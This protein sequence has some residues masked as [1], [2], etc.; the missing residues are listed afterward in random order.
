MKKSIITLTLITVIGTG[1]LALNAYA[2]NCGGPGGGYGARGWTGGYNTT[3]TDA[4]YK[5]FLDETVQIRKSIITDRAELNALMAGQNPDP[6]KAREL[7]AK[8][9]DNE[10]A[11]NGIARSANI[12]GPYGRGYGKTGLCGGPG[13]GGYGGYGNC[14]G[15]V[16]KGYGRF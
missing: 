12:N 3:V 16:G 14:S 4:D 8:I 10:E 7:A 13:S 15:P 5:K 1:F 2:W 11:L 9:A 6:V